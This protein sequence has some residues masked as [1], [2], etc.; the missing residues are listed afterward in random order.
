MN[1]VARLTGV[2]ADQGAVDNAVGAAL[3]AR[4]QG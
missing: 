3:A 2:P 1:V 4:R